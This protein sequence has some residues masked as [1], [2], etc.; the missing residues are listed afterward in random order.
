MYKV[1]QNTEENLVSDIR[2]R[3]ELK[4]KPIMDSDQ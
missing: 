2:K 1:F 3:S 4:T